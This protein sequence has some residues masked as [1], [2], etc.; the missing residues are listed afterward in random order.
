MTEQLQFDFAPDA[1]KLDHEIH[2]QINY[3][4]FVIQIAFDGI[5]YRC[6]V[7]GFGAWSQPYQTY[8]WMMF[9]VQRKI[10]I[11]RGELEVYG[12]R[13]MDKINQTGIIDID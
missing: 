4:G 9:R 10:D 3:H 5:H 8:E 1:H 11:F 13:E 7:D 12:N 2:D 6:S